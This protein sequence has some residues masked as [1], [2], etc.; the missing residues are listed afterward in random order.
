MLSDIVFTCCGAEIFLDINS[1]LR[2]GSN[3]NLTQ[4]L[5]NSLSFRFRFCNDRGMLL[6]QDA[7]RE[8]GDHNFFALGVN[9]G[10]IY[11]EWKMSNR[12]IEVSVCVIWSSQDSATHT[13]VALIMSICCKTNPSTWM[14]MWAW[15]VETSPL[16]LSP[17]ANITVT[18][19]I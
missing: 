9:S 1:F 18:N 7:K 2:F 14:K 17:Y 4:G 11:M 5:E 6:Y 12:L 19:L 15:C 16:F 3:R 8:N 10:R 13:A